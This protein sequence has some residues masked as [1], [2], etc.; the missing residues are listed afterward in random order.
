LANRRAT[1]LET[2]IQRAGI[3]ETVK[4]LA[5][6]S[7]W[8]VVRMDLKREPNLYEVASWWGLSKAQAFRYQQSFRRC[9]PALHSA[10]DMTQ[11][12]IDQGL[13]TERRIRVGLKF[14]RAMKGMGM[15]EAQRD[16]LVDRY[17]QLV[18]VAVA[19]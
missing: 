19:A 17:A 1:F 9:W 8:A 4:G 6:S 12:S 3:K 11:A 15:T 10:W 16:A 2:G 13:T 5:W 14:A 18:G 7:M